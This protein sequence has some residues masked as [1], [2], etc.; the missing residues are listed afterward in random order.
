MYHSLLFDLDG[1][2]TDSQ[3]GITKSVDHALR[4]VAGI[5]T[6]DLSTLTP[7]IGP[8]LVDGFMENHHLDAE[9]AVRCKDA[10]RARYEKVGLFENRVYDG[11]PEALGRLQDAGCTLALAT[12]KPEAFAL[13]IL[14]HFGLSKYF[15]VV[16]GATMDGRISQKDEVIGET[17]RR[18]ENPAPEDTIMIGDRRHDVLGA[19]RHGLRCLG[20][21][22]GFG[23]EAELREAGAYALA[24]T[25]Q[26][27]A[28]WLLEAQ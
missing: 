23:S 9:T 2:L 5:V 26:A 24:A 21:L 27:M 28:G 15:T 10:Y 8:P 22:F 11:I 20:V 12:S 7:Y 14:E 19:K 17:L 16:C 25:P 18:L 1:T 4:T 13:R 3:E 6:V